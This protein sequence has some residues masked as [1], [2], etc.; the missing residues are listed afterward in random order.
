MFIAHIGKSVMYKIFWCSR[1]SEIIVKRYTYYPVN[2]FKMVQNLQNK[3]NE[4]TLKYFSPTRQKSE[5][6]LYVNVP[7]YMSH[8][9][10]VTTRPDLISFAWN[11]EESGWIQGVV[12]RSYSCGYN[13][14]LSFLCSLLKE[15]IS[16]YLHA[17]WRAKM[18]L[19][20]SS[21]PIVMLQFCYFRLYSG[22]EAYNPRH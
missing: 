8:R 19:R 5:S 4:V 10:K 6:V 22:T 12:L 13:P 14:L 16:R 11:N 7:R 21:I 17:I 9:A 3:A 20:I 18:S 1:K 15:A 2:A